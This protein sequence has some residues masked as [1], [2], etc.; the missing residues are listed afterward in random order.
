[1]IIPFGGEIASLSLQIVRTGIWLLPQA[2]EG[3]NKKPFSKRM[4]FL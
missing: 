4:A 2:K 3:K 1:M